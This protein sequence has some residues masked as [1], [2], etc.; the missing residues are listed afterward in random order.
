MSSGSG[1]GSVANASPRGGAEPK[2]SAVQVAVRVRP[3]SANEATQGSESCVGVVAKSVLLDERQYD[4]DAAFPPQ[5]QQVYTM[6]NEFQ[7]RVEPAER[8]I[9][10]RV[11]DDE[12]TVKS[13]NEVAGL[14]RSGALGRATAST[15][16]NAQ[17]SRSHAICTLTMEQREVAV[18][19]DGGGTETRLSKFHLVDLAGSERVKRTNAQGARFKEGVNINRGLLSLG[20]VINALCE[21]SRTQSSTIHVPYRDSKLTRLLQDSLGGNSKTL[22]IACISPADVNYEETSNTLRYASRARSIENKAVINKELSS[23]NEVSQLKR[24][25]EIMQLQ[26]L[27]QSRGLTNSSARSIAAMAVFV[28]PSGRQ[29]AVTCELVEE[30]KRL[31]EQ[32]LLALNAKEKWKKIAD[33]L[34]DTS[35]NP[36][37]GHDGRDAVSPASST[38]SSTATGDNVAGSEFKHKTNREHDAKNVQLTR[39]E[40]LKRFQLQKAASL[41]TRQSNVVKRKTEEAVSASKRRRTTMSQPERVVLSKTNKTPDGRRNSL[42]PSVGSSLDINRG[43]EASDSQ[44]MEEVLKL[45]K[46]TFDAQLKLIETKEAI[47]VHLEERKALA[48]EIARLEAAPASG[49]SEALVK[50]RNDVKAKTG[51][52]RLL[53]QNLAHVDRSGS[54]P[55]GLF[56]SKVK[57]CHHLIRH[58][59]ETTMESKEECVSLATKLEEMTKERQTLREK[60]AAN[61]PAAKKKAR[62]PRESFETMETLFSSSSDDEEDNSEADSDYVEDDHRRPAGRRRGRGSHTPASQASGSKSGDVM[63]EIDELLEASGANCCSCHGKCA[64][65]AC[66]CKAQKQNCG[67]DCS[68][69]SEKCQNVKKDESSTANVL[70]IVVDGPSAPAAAS[71]PC[72]TAR[73]SNSTGEGSGN[74]P[75]EAAAEEPTPT[76]NGLDVAVRVRP[77]SSVEAAQACQSCVNVVAKSVLLSGKR[78]DFDAAFPPSIQQEHVHEEL[79][80]PL[81]DRFF[82][83]YNATVF[84]YGQTGSGKTFTMGN[85]FK[86]SVDPTERGIIPR[87]V[88]DVCIADWT[89]AQFI[90]NEEIYDLLA[91]KATSAASTGLAVRDDSKL[92]I[93]VAGLSEHCVE[94][95]DEVAGLLR[96]GALGRATASTTMNA[97]SSRSHA[98][99]TLTMEQREVAVAKDGGGTET[100]LSKFHL[101]DLAGSERVKRTNAQGARFKEGVNINRG[102]LSLGN[103]INA[104]CEK[105]RTQS[106]TIHV[107]YRDSKLT[108]LLQDSL[109]GNSKTLMIACISPAD[110]NYEESSNTLRYASRARSIE[111]MAV[112]NKE[113]SSENEVSQLKQQ[114]EIM[115]LQL[116][117]QSWGVSGGSGAR[118]VLAGG[119]C[120]VRSASKF[121]EGEL[122]KELR[123]LRD[124]LALALSAKDKW[125]KVADELSVNHGKKPASGFGSN[126][127]ESLAMKEAMEFEKRIQVA[128]LIPTGKGPAEA[129]S[130]LLR[131]ELA[132][133]SDVIL[134]KEKIMQELASSP[135][136]ASSDT[137]VR[138]ALLT[139]SYE[140]KIVLLE[141]EVDVLTAERRELARKMRQTQGKPSSA[142]TVSED[143]RSQSKLQ[144]LQSQLQVAKEAGKEC[145][146]LAAL[147]KAGSLK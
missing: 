141:K 109:G 23:E 39:Q 3:L 66:V 130:K 17:S 59:V 128:P 51:E 87:V 21:K 96:S 81:L 48:L 49:N 93:V 35:K 14:L 100:R 54:L 80:T 111:N 18:A 129:G 79:V 142:D 42:F 57:T 86:A 116:L 104:L 119:S 1:S 139:N 25:L 62:K 20:N 123:R 106:S 112:I 85:E 69:N 5:I 55:S 84:A 108:R 19:K 114:L 63:N 138:L 41:P 29:D 127:P 65:K 143:S 73:D 37:T 110:V 8:G 144:K 44:L 83:G 22:M 94:S 118:R 60:V 28:P 16:M 11:M 33:T 126:G 31:K 74:L 122:E 6:G 68:C 71:T 50:L 132:N 125:K 97:Q 43:S 105:S 120:S 36:S 107:P 78:Y 77:L 12:H 131:S 115:Q 9:I 45:L 2:G 13:V 67:A 92:G 10:P 91:K 26:L 7:Q 24:Q 88:D 34:A 136:L 133:L 56:P 135:S 82:D 64:T 113:L 4:F 30:N 102:L 103:V 15:T 70:G 32:L 134:E 52:I 124:Q 53:Q 95:V 38:L 117:Q 98:I 146:R 27:Q 137:G 147:W 145:K 90:L 58:L 76:S 89:L 121:D 40:Q 46:Q 61:R 99:C 140:Q 47:R 75:A 101:V 72:R